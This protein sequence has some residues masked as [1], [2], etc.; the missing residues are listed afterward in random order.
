MQL[1]VNGVLNWELNLRTVMS[2]DVC[3]HVKVILITILHVNINNNEK[4]AIFPTAMRR[5][6]LFYSF[7]N[8]FSVWFHRRTLDS[9]SASAFSLM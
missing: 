2:L 3:I 8:A 1:T 7:T 5:V 4:I 6:V 9:Y